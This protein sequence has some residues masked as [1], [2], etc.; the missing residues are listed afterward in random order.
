LAVGK[1]QIRVRVTE[2]RGTRRRWR[3]RRRRRRRRHTLRL[4]LINQSL[5]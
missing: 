1:G 2:R 4:A 3:R 5:D